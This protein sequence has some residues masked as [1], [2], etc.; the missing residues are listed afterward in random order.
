MAADCDL[1]LLLVDAA[2]ELQRADPRV[3]RIVGASASKEGLASGPEEP[4]PPA[5]LVLNKCDAVAAPQRPRLLLLADELRA[6]R[7]FEDVF[8]ISAKDGKRERLRTDARQVRWT[9]S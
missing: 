2:R 7:T 1:L 4:P 3:R 5:V 8:F 6:L 9:L